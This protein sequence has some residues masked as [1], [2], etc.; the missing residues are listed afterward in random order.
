MCHGKQAQIEVKEKFPK[1]WKK[2]QRAKCSN[3]EKNS[4]VGQIQEKEENGKKS[5]ALSRNIDFR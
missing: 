2:Q 1:L 4:E 5:P 3:Q